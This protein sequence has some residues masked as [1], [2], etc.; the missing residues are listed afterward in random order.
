LVNKPKI[1]CKFGCGEWYSFGH[2]CNA[3][4]N[5][6]DYKQKRSREDKV[7][8]SINAR[9]T[10]T[11][12]IEDAIMTD[13]NNDDLATSAW[14]RMSEDQSFDCKSK[15][16]SNKRFAHITNGPLNFLTPLYIEGKKLLGKVD[17]GSDVSIINKNLLKFFNKTNINKVNGT[18][19]FLGSGSRTKRCGRTDP[20][21]VTY[22][23]NI[24][25]EFTFEILEFD[26][27]SNNFDVLLGTDIL[28]HLNIAFTGIAVKYSDEDAEKE[29]AQFININFDQNEYTPDDSPYGSEADQKRFMTEIEPYVKKNQDIPI[30][31]F[32]TI[33]ESVVELNTKEGATA[34]HRQYPIAHSL[35]PV[36]DKQ[37]EEWLQAGTIKKCPVNTSF[38]SPL[39]L[40][41]KKNGLGQTVDYRVCMDVRGL[42]KLLPDVNFPVPLVREIFEE[43]GGKKVFTTLDLRSAYNRFKVREEDQ[44]KLTFTHHN[45]QYCFQ[46]TCFGLKHVTS[47]FCKVMAILFQDMECVQTYVDDCLIMSNDFESHIQDVKK[48][49]ERLTSVNLILNPKKCHWAHHSVHMLGFEINEKGTTVDPRK[50]TTVANWPIPKNNKDIQSF[51]GLINYFRDYIPMISKVAAPIDRMRNSHNV[52]QY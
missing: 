3:Y 32:C 52:P 48:V 40:V 45:Q 41:P 44:H 42:N 8:L 39:L 22:I 49:I 35:R 13:A 30:T 23:N 24:S 20:L 21:K 25:F 1:K 11:N 16:S 29:N 7:V 33:P 43:L 10:T 18:L 27:K 51:M 5:S 19:N 12:H 26:E 4:Y 36:L 9:T 46:G 6:D 34:Y 17:T 37:I 2:K 15:D 28:C 47:V 31:S 50:L 14:K 38:N